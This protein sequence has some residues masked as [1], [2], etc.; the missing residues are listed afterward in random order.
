MVHL[1]SFLTVS[2]RATIGRPLGASSVRST[3][4]SWS[5]GVDEEQGLQPLDAFVLDMPYGGYPY[6]QTQVSQNF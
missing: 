4:T 1:F 3:D 6:R 5:P 2:N